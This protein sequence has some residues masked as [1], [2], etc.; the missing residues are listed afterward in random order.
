MDK[1]T[2]E[3][4]IQATSGNFGALSLSQ[5]LG[6]DALTGRL[7]LEKAVDC[8]ITGA[9]L[10]L[11]WNDVHHRDFTATREALLLGQAQGQLQNTYGSKYYAQSE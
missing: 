5:L 8:D 10:Y 3:L 1:A 7:A 2:S 11:L 6:S 9:E 4:I